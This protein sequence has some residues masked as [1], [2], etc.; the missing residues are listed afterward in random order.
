MYLNY[1]HILSRFLDLKILFLLYVNLHI[2]VTQ[3]MKSN[4]VLLFDYN[5][6][7]KNRCWVGILLSFSAVFLFYLLR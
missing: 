7:M 5:S 4:W 1:K 6:N 3:G 2:D